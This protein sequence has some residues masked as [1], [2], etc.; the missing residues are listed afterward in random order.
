M[1]FSCMPE[2]GPCLYQMYKLILCCPCHYC[3]L[4]AVLFL[5]S[6]QNRFWLPVLDRTAA[7]AAVLV[8]EL[9]LAD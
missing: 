2:R 6:S 3:F 7:L 4:A 8:P 9:V 1:G 5:G